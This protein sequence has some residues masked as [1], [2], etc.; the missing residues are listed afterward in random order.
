MAILKTYDWHSITFYYKMQSHLLTVFI[1]AVLLWLAWCW[2]QVC[3]AWW[4]VWDAVIGPAL[5]CILAERFSW[6]AGKACLCLFVSCACQV[7]IC[8]WMALQENA[9]NQCLHLHFP[10]IPK[11][12]FERQMTVFFLQCFTV[13][14]NVHVKQQC[15]NCQ[16]ILFL[17]STVKIH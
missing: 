1:W 17:I 9:T 8:K 14:C 3:K 12:C 4:E 6:T 7:C 16:E 13:L 2:A 11:A 5:K 15:Y 10:I